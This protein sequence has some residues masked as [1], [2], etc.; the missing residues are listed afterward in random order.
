L[1]DDLDSGNGADSESEADAPTTIS[2]KLIVAYL[3]DYD[4][5]DPVEN[6][7]EWILNKNIAF[8][9]S[10]CL[11]DVSVNIRSMHMP[12]PISKIACMHIQD[13]EGSVFIVP[14]YKRDL[15]PIVF[16]RGRAQASIPSELDDDLEHPQF[17]YNA[18]SLHRM[19]KRME[20][21]LNR[22]EGLNFGKE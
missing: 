13:N 12:L 21:S 4:C 1:P 8:D 14:P 17:F 19:I 5:N 6:E 22:G 9:Y 18:R 7:S 16:G 20:Y 10:L 15:S 11:E 3:N 2:I